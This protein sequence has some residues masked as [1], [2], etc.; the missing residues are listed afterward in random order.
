MGIFICERSP[1]PKKSD[2]AAT[3]SPIDV[4]NRKARFISTKS[5]RGLFVFERIILI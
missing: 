4:E 3:P 1:P 5:G 2:G